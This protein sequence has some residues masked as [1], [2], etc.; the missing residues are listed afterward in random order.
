MRQTGPV[1][2]PHA[3]GGDNRD[4]MCFGRGVF[5]KPE[6]LKSWPFYR[7]R[8]EQK[9]F[10]KTI[11]TGGTPFQRSLLY[12]CRFSSWDVPFTPQP[13]SPQASAL[14]TLLVVCFVFGMVWDGG[15]PTGVVSEFLFLANVCRNGRKQSTF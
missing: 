5:N 10:L 8:N 2:V 3:A 1:V 6:R 4:R 9:N 14:L 11:I 7:K 12:F 15:A 13:H